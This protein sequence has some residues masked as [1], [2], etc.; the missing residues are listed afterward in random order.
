MVA[1]EASVGRQR[2]PVASRVRR[3]LSP[4]E[5]HAIREMVRQAR[6]SGAAFTGP[7]RLVEA[8]D[9]VG[10]EAALLDKELA[11][12]VGYDKDA[13]GRNGGKSA[14]IAASV[15]PMSDTEGAARRALWT[16]R[17]RPA[18]SRQ[19]STTPERPRVVHLYALTRRR[20]ESTSPS[21]PPDSHTFTTRTTGPRSVYTSGTFAVRG[22]VVPPPSS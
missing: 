1:E 13:L 21:S 2:L 15:D 4:A 8:A 9:Q 11:E 17:Y 22:P 18:C 10:V 16:Q 14:S 7:E 5:T 12:R 3:E 19:H 6:A 20:C